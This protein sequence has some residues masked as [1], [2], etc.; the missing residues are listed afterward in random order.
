[1][2]YTA[3]NDILPQDISKD[4]IPRIF[5]IVQSNGSCVTIYFK[6]NVAGNITLLLFGTLDNLHGHFFIYDQKIEPTSHH[7]T[8]HQHKQKNRKNNNGCEFL[9]FSSIN[10]LQQSLF[11][12]HQN[13]TKTKSK[14]SIRWCT[15]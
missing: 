2:T 5:K 12:H 14:R 11:F 4:S 9:V 15:S 13:K 7:H 6:I 3:K 10:I 8:H 1:M